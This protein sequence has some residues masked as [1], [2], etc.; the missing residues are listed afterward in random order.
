MDELTGL[1]RYPQ[2]LKELVFSKSCP[3]VTQPGQE[4]CLSLEKFRDLTKFQFLMSTP[5]EILNRLFGSI[6]NPEKLKTL[7]FFMPEFQ[8]KNQGQE[9]TIC[10]PSKDFLAKCINLERLC[11]FLDMWT[12]IL[13]ALSGMRLKKLELYTVLKDIDP[14]IQCLREQTSLE[15]LSINI[16]FLNFTDESLI[17]L[18]ELFEGLEGLKALRKLRFRLRTPSFV[19]N[20]TGKVVPVVP[21]LISAINQFEALE[22]LSFINLEGDFKE[23]LVEFLAALQKKAKTLRKIELDLNSCIFDG[24][25]S[26]LLT[27]TLGKLEL[28]EEVSLK[29]F[30]VSDD[31][32]F[33]WF[34]DFLSNNK[35]LRGVEIDNIERVIENY[36]PQGLLDMLRKAL[37]KR[38]LRR[39]SYLESWKPGLQDPFKNVK[40]LNPREVIKKDTN[41]EYLY[42]PSYIY[43]F[44]AITFDINAYK[45][46]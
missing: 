39:F 35:K 6:A 36:N 46:K 12:E 29:R 17:K 40:K 2:T 43:S 18:C 32:F 44:E 23:S 33:G 10:Q 31:R 26:R 42:I 11:I 14:L 3:L 27:Q 13:P 5:I 38:E 30:K 37:G 1:N 45:W 34:L 8:S 15:S 9:N 24:E 16:N 20:L 25:S 22:E 28:L 4:H 21:A 7:G 41:L 19:K